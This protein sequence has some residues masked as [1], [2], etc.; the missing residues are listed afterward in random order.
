MK[1]TIG[2][3]YPDLLNLYGEVRIVVSSKRFIGYH[4]K[5]LVSGFRDALVMNTG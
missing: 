1:L 3:L 5:A 4:F 2:H